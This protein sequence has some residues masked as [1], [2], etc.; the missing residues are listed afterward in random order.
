MSDVED[1]ESR[2]SSIEF[3]N[4]ASLKRDRTGTYLLQI[5]ERQNQELQLLSVVP[6]PPRI[7][8]GGQRG[9]RL[10]RTEQCTSQKFKC[11]KVSS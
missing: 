6:L 3:S 2:S 8:G 10:H 4:V 11:L 1:E 7:I 5:A 9:R